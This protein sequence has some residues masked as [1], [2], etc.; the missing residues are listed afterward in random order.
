MRLETRK[1]WLLFIAAFGIL[2]LL[3]RFTEKITQKQ[4]EE[5]KKPEQMWENTAEE[6]IRTQ[7]NQLKIAEYKGR[8]ALTFDDGPSKLMTP[9]LLDGLEKR[10]VKATFF[11][12]GEYAEENQELVKRMSEAGHL[13]GNHTYHHVQLKDLG[14][15]E[16]KR[17][18]DETNDL[19]EQIT[20]NRPQFLRPPFGAW[21]KTLEK[22]VNMIPVMWDVDPLD[23]CREDVDCIVK[24]V[25]EHV[26]DNDIILLHDSYATSVTAA[27]Q[28]IDILQ[29]LGYEFV[30][31]DELM[32][33]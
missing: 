6:M 4:L 25:V 15:E 10:G 21:D 24:S 12:I 2:A 18:I 16:V 19:L 9:Q 30:T 17:E 5:G 26:K 8:V 29:A 22:K 14:K 31:V 28:I 1:K 20:G 27:L 32:T 7:G 11:L 23:W 13:I 3:A 33:E